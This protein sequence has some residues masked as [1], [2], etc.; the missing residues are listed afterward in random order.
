MESVPQVLRIFCLKTGEV[1]FSEWFLEL[2]DSRAKQKIIARLTR[3]RAGNFGRTNSVGQ[4]VRE[5]KIDYGPG[6]R[7]YYGIHGDELI[8]IL[9]A[10]SK[11]TQTADIKKARTYWIEW[12]ETNT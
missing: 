4:G 3:L 12:K 2:R 6:Y 5:L 1:P 8:L 10:G 11:R 9:V 7:V